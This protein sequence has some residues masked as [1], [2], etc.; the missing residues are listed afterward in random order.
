[1][2][3]AYS[4]YNSCLRARGMTANR[5]AQPKNNMPTSKT[6]ANRLV[7]SEIEI[8][9][10][11]TYICHLVTT[12]TIYLFFYLHL[13]RCDNNYNN[14]ERTIHHNYKCLLRARI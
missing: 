4:R 10:H 1:M 7:Y 13:Y 14:R 11:S 5:N 8:T 9:L 2:F 12:V 6:S 3:V